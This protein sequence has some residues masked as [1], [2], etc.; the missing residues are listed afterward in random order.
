MY[1]NSMNSKGTHLQGI[2]FKQTLD[3]FIKLMFSKKPNKE[4]YSEI[5]KK[6]QTFIENR[7]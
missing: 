5:E 2:I 7:K 3:D 1:T 4:T 6:V